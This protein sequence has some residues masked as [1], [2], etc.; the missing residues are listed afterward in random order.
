MMKMKTV[1]TA[2]IA[3]I[4]LWL[5]AGCSTAPGQPDYHAEQQ[6]QG[7]EKAQQE[8]SREVKKTY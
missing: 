3:S 4:L 1:G 7:A 6:R 5:M 2:L 8:L